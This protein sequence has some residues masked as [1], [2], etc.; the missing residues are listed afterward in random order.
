MTVLLIP[1]LKSITKDPTLKSN[2]RPIAIAN[3]ASKILEMVV[4]DIIRHSLDT[5]EY[6]FGF[7]AKLGTEIC[8]YSLKKTI[9]YYYSKNTP[10]FL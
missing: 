2:Y 9:D 3:Q 4:L 6:Q 5:S 1:L 8:I 10:I 7:K